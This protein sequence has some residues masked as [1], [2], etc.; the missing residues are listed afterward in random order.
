[1][2]T[3]VSTTINGS[4]KSFV[5]LL[6]ISFNGSTGLDKQEPSAIPGWW[7]L[8]LQ[9]SNHLFT[10]NWLGNVHTDFISYQYQVNSPWSSSLQVVQAAD[11][12]GEVAAVE[13]S[14]DGRALAVKSSN[15]TMINHGN[16]RG[17]SV[18]KFAEELFNRY[19]IKSDCNHLT[20]FW[21]D[22]MGADS[23]RQMTSKFPSSSPL[24]E[25]SMCL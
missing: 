8:P 16:W 18:L 15:Q 2:I 5:P 13:W 14:L 12:S 21:I 17:G 11:V 20:S 1:M 7:D 19:Q 6:S 10:G 9:L 25:A 3:S 4:Q 22:L 23:R 24:V